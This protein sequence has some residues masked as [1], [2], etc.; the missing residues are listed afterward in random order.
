[1]SVERK[2]LIFITEIEQLSADTISSFEMMG[3]ELTPDYDPDQH[4]S[5]LFAIVNAL[6][7]GVHLPILRLKKMD[8]FEMGL[9]NKVR[10]YLDPSY[11]GKKPVFD[12]LNLHMDG[13]F[14][15][16]DYYAASYKNT[17]CVKVQDYLNIGYFTDVVV[18]AAYRA[19]FN[20][21]KIRKYMSECFKYCFKIIEP[22]E[23]QFS[24]D[25]IYSYSEEGFAVQIH[26]NCE[27]FNPE[28]NFKVPNVSVN[29]F[30]HYANYVDVS[31]F[32][33][34]SR[35]T[36]SSVWFADKELAKFNSLFF[37][38]VFYR[39]FKK[40]IGTHV[41]NM[42]EDLNRTEY[43]ALANY[44]TQ[45]RKMTAAR[46]FAIFIRHYRKSEEGPK[47]ADQLEPAD[48]VQYLRS[49]PR[50]SSVK[51]LDQ[52]LLSFVIQ[53]I[54]NNEL[55]TGVSAYIH[56]ASRTVLSPVIEEIRHQISEKTL[57]EMGEIILSRVDVLV[58]KDEELPVE[59]EAQVRALTEASDDDED[60]PQIPHD[61]HESEASWETKSSEVAQ[62]IEDEII[63][64]KSSYK[65][66]VADD[67][68][69]VVSASIA[70]QEKH[71][72]RVRAFIEALIAEENTLSKAEI[73]R[74]TY[75]PVEYD[76]EKMLDQI[77]RMKKM[78]NQMKHEIVR[79]RRNPQA[80]SISA[81]THEIITEEGET[82]VVTVH[83]KEIY[84][85]NL[86]LRN[87][88][89][90]GMVVLRE[91]EEVHSKMKRDFDKAIR[92]LQ[93]HK[94]SVDENRHELESK[95]NEAIADNKELEAKLDTSAQKLSVVNESMEHRDHDADDIIQRKDKEIEGL[96]E[97]LKASEALAEHFKSERH[98]F[99]VKLR[100]EEQLTKKLRDE[101]T[102]NADARE[103]PQQGNLNKINA[104]TSEL[105]AFE[106]RFRAQSLEVKK[107]EQ[108]L[109]YTNVQVEEH[110]KKKSQM[111]NSNN[112]STE[113]YAKQLES[114]ATRVNE[115]LAE[116]TEK[117][118]EIHKLKQENF[119]MST[120]ITELER[121]LNI[122]DKKAS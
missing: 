39:V 46:K 21:E 9:L 71:I 29:D 113:A 105:K 90:R 119:V 10:A 2:K 86:K 72:F 67:I 22:Y 78:L 108:K 94:I 98:T 26:L 48:I 103:N 83:D 40:D 19:R 41:I 61:H 95:I 63:R 31:F 82:K 110:Q 4:E 93:E 101:K 17:Y 62:K 35:L 97:N 51:R 55:Y 15:V 70:I 49:Y 122:L 74:E 47:S 116:V 14:N 56:K 16:I 85:E 25:V 77:F 92:L 102:E 66:L 20:I 120:R 34:R 75:V 89:E 73:A 36:I 59:D 53:L 12:L 58:D 37:T 109:K 3:I 45:A 114:A 91:R 33:K 42:I 27:E 32:K 81:P 13:G 112:K 38:D 7:A 88:I 80:V 115:A 52:E 107:L 54:R 60:M 84:E 57:V 5:Y 23:E 111:A 118:K 43:K 69:K 24:L 76:K 30:Y 79:L 28:R 1:M 44:A 6:P 100:Q 18:S 64:V 117:K 96:K 65:E 121:K 8:K 68:M 104:L 11:I 50:Q 87:A 106:E 99:E